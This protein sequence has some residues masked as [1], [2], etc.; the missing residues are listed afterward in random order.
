[1]RR[2]R[3]LRLVR[4]ALRLAE[5]RDR[6]KRFRSSPVLRSPVLPRAQYRVGQFYVDGA[7]RPHEAA[8]M[9]CAA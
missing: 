2:Y 9:A 1:L 4:R 6:F 5:K 3:L 8:S 7:G